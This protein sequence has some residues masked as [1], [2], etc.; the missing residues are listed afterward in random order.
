MGVCGLPKISLG[1]MEKHLVLLAGSGSLDQ[2]L[3]CVERS[4]VTNGPL[5]LRHSLLST[6]QEALDQTYAGLEG[7]SREVSRESPPRRTRI[8]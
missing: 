4:P 8:V 3:E 1:Q 5:V 6:E 2:V 7:L